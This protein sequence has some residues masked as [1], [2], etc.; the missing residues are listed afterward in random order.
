MGSHQQ[1][2]RFR[3]GV[4]IPLPGNASYCVEAFCI[5]TSVS[6][7]SAYGARFGHAVLRANDRLR[8]SPVEAHEVPLVPFAVQLV[9]FGALG[10]LAVMDFLSEFHR[11][12]AE[13]FALPAL[14]R[15]LAVLSDLV[16]GQ[17]I[18]RVLDQPRHH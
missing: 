16:L 18:R 12:S 8:C 5:P 3:I 2:L 11:W 9:L 15:S 13:G 4:G 6:T 7:N 1:L 17:A 14:I 10:A